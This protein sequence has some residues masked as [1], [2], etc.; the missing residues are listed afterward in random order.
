MSSFKTNRLIFAIGALIIGIILLIWPGA[1]LMII[2]RCIGAVLAAGGIVA[3]FL[4]W[5][6]H[7]AMSRTLLLVMA[8]VMLICG[9]V[10]ILHPD[11][12]VKLIPT[13][14][15]VL[16]VM[17]GLIN[18]GE[19]FLLNR[20]KYGKWWISL[21]VA[22]L[23]IAAGVFV[24]R[25]AFSLVSIITRLA[26]GVMVFSGCSDLWVLSRLAYAEKKAAEP[27]DAAAAGTAPAA[28]DAA[29]GTAP[30]AGDAAASGTAPAAGDAPAGNVPTDAVKTPAAPV[31]AAPAP[32]APVDAAPAN[33]VA[34]DAAPAD[35]VNAPAAPMAAAL[36]PDVPADAAP[37]NTVAADAAPAPAAP[38]DIANE[39]VAPA[40][41]AAAGTEPH[42]EDFRNVSP[43]LVW[44]DEGTE[45]GQAEVPEYMRQEEQPGDYKAPE[46]DT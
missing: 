36:E 38:E 24:I 35:A 43:S 30:A 12:L 28:G 40:D 4:F 23:K 37:A 41:A 39:P 26:G 25:N 8:A 22:A 6:D 14:M 29:A 5:K 31:E 44:D 3:A 32:A 19:T 2:G 20:K 17:S 18:I 9:I 45:A 16:A 11:E 15:G 21:I 10:I 1:S 33:T 27:A 34:A 7:E 46:E 42:A 13:I